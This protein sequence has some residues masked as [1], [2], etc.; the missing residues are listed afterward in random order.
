MLKLNNHRS[1]FKLCS[2]SRLMSTK[3]NNENKDYERQYADNTFKM[4]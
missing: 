1:V 4:F 3:N 2:L